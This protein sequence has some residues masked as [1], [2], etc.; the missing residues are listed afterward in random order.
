[1]KK[2]LFFYEGMLLEEF[3]NIRYLI[4]DEF[5]EEFVINLYT[6]LDEYKFT[7]ETISILS[8]VEINTLENFINKKG[9]LTYDEINMIE[10]CVLLPL[11]KVLEVCEHNFKM[12]VLTKK[13]RDDID[14]Y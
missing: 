6:L 12:K 3:K 9:G 10:D 14:L 8:K 7:L 1:M 11:I 5:I 4:N 13:I 2:E